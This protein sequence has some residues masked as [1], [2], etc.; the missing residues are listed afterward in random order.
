MTELTDRLRHRVVPAVPVP[1]DVDGGI[2]DAA[3]LQYAQWMATQPVG[4]VAVW[5]HTGRGLLLS[6]SQRARVLEMWLGALKETPIICGV[7]APDT[8]ELPTDPRARTDRV[9]ELAVSVAAAARD[10]GAAGL[11]VYPPTALRDLQDLNDRVV[12]LHRAIAD[13]GLPTIAFYLYHDAGGISYAFETINRL[14]D[15]GGVIGIKVATLD[16]V[17]TFQ[18]VAGEVLR[19]TGALLISGEDRFLGYSLTLGAHCALIGMAAACTESSAALLDSWFERDL[20]SFVTLGADLD[21]FAGATF[22]APIDG[23]V[24][25]MLWALE[26][27]GVLPPYPHDPFG[28]DLTEEDRAVVRNAVVKLRK[29]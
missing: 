22:R 2:D 8:E 6:E 14:L 17:M 15:L 3:V 12:E 9:I 25:R 20:E 4:A 13:V 19:H 21:E 26:A 10:G 27:D 7:G 23:Y 5:A 28:P 11:L 24:Q 16:S 29:R 1:F 18:D